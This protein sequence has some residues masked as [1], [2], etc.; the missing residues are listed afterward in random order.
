MPAAAS[1]GTTSR[2]IAAMLSTTE[3]LSWLKKS[4]QSISRSSGWNRA[5]ICSATS[6]GL[7]TSALSAASATLAGSTVPSMACQYAAS[8]RS[9]SSRAAGRVVRLAH[10][11]VRRLDHV[12]LGDAEV[13]DPY[14]RE[15]VEVNLQG[16]VVRAE[17]QPQQLPA[18][19]G[20]HDLGHLERPAARHGQ[21]V[22]IGTGEVAHAQPQLR[23]AEMLGAQ[24][25][26]R[27]VVTGQGLAGQQAYEDLA[28]LPHHGAAR[29]RPRG[30]LP[31]GSRADPA[32]AVDVVEPAGGEPDAEPAQLLRVETVPGD[33]HGDPLGGGQRAAVADDVQDR[34]TDVEPPGAG[35]DPGRE[36]TDVGVEADLALPVGHHRLA[37]ELLHLGAVVALGDPHRAVPELVG[38]LAL[39]E[40]VAQHGRLGR[41]NAVDRRLRDAAEQIESQPPAPPKGQG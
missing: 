30:A 29:L 18:D 4:N 31:L 16:R 41:Q 10:P 27:H 3:S 35:E 37:V 20:R 36:L 12:R 40:E 25:E 7:P 32:E 1:L 5:R 2:A 14:R 28:C 8:T 34:R 26:L 33:R 39:G 11:L 23:V 24:P 13:E 6:A 9:A 38:R 19:V 15:P 21:L 17:Q 22:A